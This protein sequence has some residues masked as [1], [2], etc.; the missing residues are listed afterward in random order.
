MAVF[1]SIKEKAFK[2]GDDN[3]SPSDLGVGRLSVA[4]FSLQDGTV[5]LEAVED[6]PVLLVTF[7][8]PEG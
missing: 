8:A 5:R 1:S 3:I 4:L 6:K 7:E 2:F